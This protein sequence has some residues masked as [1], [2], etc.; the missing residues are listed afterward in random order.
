MDALSHLAAGFGVAL[1]PLNLFL[2]LIG[3]VVGT[4]IGVLPGI[5]PLNAIA[6]LL[7][8]CFA[9]QLPPESGLILLAA[10]YYGSGYGGRL[11]ANLLNIP[12]EPPAVLTT[13]GGAPFGRGGG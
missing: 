13:V 12:G 9:L 4:A 2:A 10:I 1:T 3:C 5:G 6:L 8:F 7:P 11:T